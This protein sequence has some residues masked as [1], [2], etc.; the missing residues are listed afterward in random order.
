MLTPMNTKIIHLFNDDEKH[1][2]CGWMT[3]SNTIKSRDIGLVNCEKC[4]S[5]FNKSVQAQTGNIVG[6][7]NA[8]TEMSPLQQ[9]S[10]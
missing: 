9:N 8:N 7:Q 2:Y 6:G 3:E 1:T 4:L 5:L 10:H